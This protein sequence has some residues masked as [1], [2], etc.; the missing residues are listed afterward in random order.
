[1]D[2]VKTMILKLYKKI[3]YRRSL[4]NSESYRVVFTAT[5]LAQERNRLEVNLC[6]RPSLRF[7]GSLEL[8]YDLIYLNDPM[9]D[10]IFATSIH[11]DSTSRES[12]TK[13]TL[14]APLYQGV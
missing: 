6:E 1:M 2:L 12:V 11:V 10:R 3:L 13:A 8:I 9:P 4:G 5:E 14:L 7:Q